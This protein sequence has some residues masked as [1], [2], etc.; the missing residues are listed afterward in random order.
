M[1]SSRGFD[2]R[3]HEGRNDGVRVEEVDR[4]DVVGNHACEFGAH[5]L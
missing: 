5:H 3:E 2:A 1:G 4:G